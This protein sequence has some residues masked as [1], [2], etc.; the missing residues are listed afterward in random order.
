MPP[1]AP[2]KEGYVFKGWVTGQDGDQLTALPE[3]MG[4]ENI[5]AYA[6]WEFK[7]VTVKYV[8]DG[9][10]VS[11]KTVP[12]GSSMNATIPADPAKEGYT[13]AG[14]FDAEG[15]SAHSYTTVPA[16]D[17]TF[18][19]KWLKDGNV[20]YVVDGKTFKEYPVKEG[21]PIPV[22]EEEPKK[23]GYKFTGWAPEA[24]EAMGTENL[25]FEAQFE[26]DKEFIT[27][28]VGG[29]AIAGAVIACL[30][31]TSDAADE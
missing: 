20:K 21:D 14:W 29:T 1:E 8:S 10:E 22:P 28:V 26:L 2:T 31:Y 25:V 18:T 12:Y 16:E 5:T 24:P 17:I 7:Q 23:F 11:S 30:L 27:Y 15:I 3:T 4:T 13:F 9:V 19:A 6:A